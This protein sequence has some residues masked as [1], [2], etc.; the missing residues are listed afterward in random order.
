MNKDI[1]LSP[2]AFGLGE[3]VENPG[4]QAVIVILEASAPENAEDLVRVALAG[5]PVPLRLQRGS[6]PPQG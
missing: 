3:T 5:V 4:E 2:A 6:A 1:G